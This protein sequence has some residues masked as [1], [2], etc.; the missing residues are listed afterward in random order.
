MVIFSGT[1]FF[2][3]ALSFF[4]IS[5][6]MINFSTTSS[7][8]KLDIEFQKQKFDNFNKLSP[9]FMLLLQWLKLL[10]HVFDHCW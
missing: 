6:L 2:F 10:S 5:G 8:V 4:I 7:P 9:I 1:F 3:C